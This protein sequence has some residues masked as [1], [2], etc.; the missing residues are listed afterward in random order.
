VELL[1]VIDTDTPSI[2]TI[3]SI[4]LKKPM[5]RIRQVHKITCIFP[6]LPAN[7]PF[8]LLFRVGSMMLNQLVAGYCP[9]KLLVELSSRST[10]KNAGNWQ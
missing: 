10:I 5:V 2:P 7:K 4:A 1:A 3:L 9:Y 6:P 8:F